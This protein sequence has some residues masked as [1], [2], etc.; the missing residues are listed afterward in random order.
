MVVNL[1]VYRKSSCNTPTIFQYGYIG[2]TRVVGQKTSCPSFFKIWTIMYVMF[3]HIRQ[4]KKNEPNVTTRSPLHS[5]FCN[6]FGQEDHT[7]AKNI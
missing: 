6:S 5:K 3:V 4:Y 2:N 1:C 7:S